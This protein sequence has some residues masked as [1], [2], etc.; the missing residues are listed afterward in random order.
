[1]LWLRSLVFNIAFYLW[2]TFVVV[3]AVP[4]LAF[5]RHAALAVARF[6]ARGVSFL[7]KRICRIDFRIEGE[8]N[9]PHAAALVASKHQS[10]WDT[11]I[12]VQL[13]DDPAY[14]LKREL[15]HIP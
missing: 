6:W 8:E 9:M 1:M 4:S 10:A 5:N 7:L 12:F 3:G 14:V 11:F 13:L 15:M 2:T